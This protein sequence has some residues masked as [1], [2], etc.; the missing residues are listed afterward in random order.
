MFMISINDLTFSYRRKQHLFDELQLEIPKGR[1]YG[2]LGKNGAGKTTLLKLISGLLFPNKGDI[3]M[4][5]YN[6]KHRNPE[7]LQDIYFVAEEFELPAMTIKQYINLH[8]PFY[9]RFK[10]DQMEHFLSEFELSPERKLNNMSYGQKKK[11]LVSFGLATN[12]KLLIMDEPTNGLDIPS[13][14]QF[15]KIVASSLTEE[16]TVIVSTHQVRDL[17]GLIDAVVILDDGRIIFNHT[18]ESVSEKLYFGKGTT[19]MVDKGAAIYTEDVM[20]IKTIIAESTNSEPSKVDLELLFNATTTKPEAI[21]NA[22]AQTGKV[23]ENN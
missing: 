18:I 2:L 21:N 22:L 9:P 6:P 7:F 13:K 15:R 19:K 4:E 16:H 12:C 10:K 23:L 14:S 1:I 11:F 3:D 5:G 17:D 8:A 20:G